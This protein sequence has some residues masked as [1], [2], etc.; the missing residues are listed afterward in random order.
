MS[1]GQWL[2]RQ[3]HGVAGLFWFVVPNMCALAL[4]A[5]LAPKIRKKMP[6]GYTLPQWI[7]HQLGSESVHKMY[8][9]PYFFYQLMAVAVQLYAGG[10]LLALLLGVPVYQAV[11]VITIAVLG[12]I[13]LFYSLISGL[14][15]SILTDFFQLVLIIVALLIIIPWMIGTVGLDAITA[16]L[17]G[18]EGSA[19]IFDPGIA[20]SL[21]IVTAIG[22]LSGAI[23]DQQYWQRGFALREGHVKKAFIF[24][25]L[26]FGVVPIALGLLGF[27]GA[28]ADY[29]I[30]IPQG[31]D[32][33]LIG[34]VVVSKLLPLWTA[35]LFVVML[36]SALSS[37]LDSGMN[38]A[39]SLYATDVMK[40]SDYEKDLMIRSEK[41]DTLTDKEK[42][43]KH[44]LDARRMRGS[45]TTMVVLTLLGFMV[46]V[47]I[48]Y[49][50]KFQMQ[51]LWW[52]FNTIAAS[53]VVP[54]IL[55]LYWDGL[56]AK[57]VFW[58]V[59]TSFFIGL[60]LFVY[61]NFME[62]PVW[63]VGS[64]LF[65]VLVTLFFCVAFPKPSK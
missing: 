31:I 5:V 65:V 41:Q 50:P 47:A 25:A 3:I 62:K 19:N 28:N 46:A 53:V 54:T 38:A 8:L 23:S 33:S 48:I 59:L 35:F 61:S 30:T 9:F 13:P 24:G 26:V 55:S 4:F 32:P 15:A 63:I 43:D 7:R 27:I 52:V 51:Q 44:M 1:E 17:A 57:G 10:N 64:S 56:S 21:G 22:L 29:A 42:L 58:G 40:F 18:L 14:E 16:G 45:R 20:F 60:P 34:V 11:A 12:A 36:I 37:T 49:I 6:L 39:A 2:K